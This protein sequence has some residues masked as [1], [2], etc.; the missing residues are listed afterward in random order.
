MTYTNGAGHNNVEQLLQSIRSSI[1]DNPMRSQRRGMMG[2][3]S[4]VRSHGDP[5]SQSAGANSFDGTHDINS[6]SGVEALRA[7]LMAQ[8]ER[9]RFAGSRP[10][11]PIADD[12]A[13]FE[14]PAI[15]KA[16]AT[17]A[18]ASAERSHLLDRLSD[19]LLTTTEAAPEAPEVT[20]AAGDAESRDNG[21]TIIRFEPAFTR[22]TRQ[23]RDPRDAA[24]PA[25]AATTDGR[26]ANADEG[27]Q[28]DRITKDNDSVKR[29]MPTF[30][31]TRMKMLSQPAS[32]PPAAAEPVAATP[33]PVPQQASHP[34]PYPVSPSLPMPSHALTVP[35]DAEMDTA[36]DDMAAQML[37]PI[38]REWLSENMPK[39][40][41]R[42]LRSEMTNGTGPAAGNG[43]GAKPK[44]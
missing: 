22:D 36:M 11:L 4:P 29:V 38:L 18:E 27:N 30:F 15:F 44:A 10:D 19:V 2:A 26:N 34:D 32:P 23:S 31:D 20:E 6:S 24:R 35:A 9:A 43:P 14:L 13:E 41:E 12:S 25:D 42:A 21:R 40:V 39:I 7:D 1:G 8:Q 5:R 37:R 28:L 16:Q 17:P 3:S 33:P